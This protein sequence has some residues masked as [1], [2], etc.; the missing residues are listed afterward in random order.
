MRFT[1]IDNCVNISTDGVI[2]YFVKYLS[3]PC[4]G[5]YYPARTT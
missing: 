1:I 2:E 4:S 3:Q 5:L